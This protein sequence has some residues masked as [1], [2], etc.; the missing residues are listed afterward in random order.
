MVVVDRIQRKYGEDPDQDLIES[1]GNAYLNRNFPDLS[2]IVDL[3]AGNV[4]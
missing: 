3:V 2:F 4:V 1:E